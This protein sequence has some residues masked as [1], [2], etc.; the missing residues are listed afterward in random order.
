MTKNAQ[1][2]RLSR[3]S[4]LIIVLI[5]VSNIA[6]IAYSLAYQLR[7]EIKLTNSAAQKTRAWHL[8]IAGIERCRS[9]LLQA[10][11]DETKN[12]GVCKFFS[13]EENRTLFS[14]LNLE[15]HEEPKL[16]CWIRD[17]KGYLDINKSDPASWQHFEISDEQTACILDW[18]DSDSQANPAGAEVDYYSSTQPFYNCKNAPLVTIRELTFIKGIS[19]DN[20][21]WE[22]LKNSE[23]EPDD[24][25]ELFS[26]PDNQPMTLTDMFT[27]YGDST[28]NINTAP[29]NILAA[30]VAIEQQTVDAVLNYRSG[31]DGSLGTDDDMPIEKTEDIFNIPGISDIQLELLTQY[32]CFDSDTYR[33]FSYAKSGQQ[34]CMLMA[35]LRVDDQ[36]CKIL[37]VERLI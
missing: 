6:I 5:V 12:A 17:E 36:T 22:E 15:N 26:N 20:Y 3:G 2:N 24:T 19:T 11:Q 8:A 13:I 23:Y 29:A 33:I 9:Q 35:S 4:V 1:K 10:G 25:E 16:V 30:L 27:V 28:V 31:P 37:C 21:T 32:C 7:I 18:Q 34:R 14:N